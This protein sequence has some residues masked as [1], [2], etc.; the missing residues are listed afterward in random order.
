MRGL[1]Y[2]SSSTL[3]GQLLPQQ[4]FPKCSNQF[5]LFFSE[6]LIIIENEAGSVWRKDAYVEPARQVWGV[7]APLV[8]M[9]TT[10]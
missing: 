7:L 6:R 3:A 9:E 1:L 2:S 5:H 8:V 10:W 4:H